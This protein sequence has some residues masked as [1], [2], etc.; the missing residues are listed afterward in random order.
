MQRSGSVPSYSYSQPR[1]SYSE[2]QPRP[3]YSYSQPRPSYPATARDSY[4][5]SVTT[6]P[7]RESTA[8]YSEPATTQLQR[9]P[10]R[11]S[12][13]ESQTRPSYSECQTDP[14]T[15]SARPTQLQ[16]DLATASQLAELDLRAEL[17]IN[18]STPTISTAHTMAVLLSRYGVTRFTAQTLYLLGPVEHFRASLL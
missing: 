13:S 5:D 12:Y 11:P 16:R 1:P 6:Q 4:R 9:E 7:Q 2:S 10:A 3:S 18:S 17:Q 8:S 14:A 15:A